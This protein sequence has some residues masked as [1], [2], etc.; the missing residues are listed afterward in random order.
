M[1]TATTQEL[2]QELLA[3]KPAKLTELCL[4]LAR[5]KKE[6]KELLTYLLFEAGDEENY[7]GSVKEELEDAFSELPKPNLYLSKKTLRKILR[8]A[9]RYTRYAGSKTVEASV[10]LHF[11]RKM[12]DC[13]IDFSG[14]MVMQNLYE[15]QLK[16]IRTAIKSL[17][18]DMQYDLQRELEGL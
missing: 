2:K 14:S 12:K 7:I 6:N 1:K 3:L 16:K 15:A 11:C 4:R 5:F 18:E 13:G 8:I 10:L 9:N 17:H